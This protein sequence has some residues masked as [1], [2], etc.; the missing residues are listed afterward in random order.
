MKEPSIKEKRTIRFMVFIGIL[1]MT[2]FVFWFY[3]LGY[4]PSLLFWVLSISLG[5]GFLRI[6]YMWYHYISIKIPKKPHGNSKFTVDILTTYFPGEPYEMILET[7]DAIQK[8]TYPHT[9]YLCDEANDPYLKEACNKLNVVHVTRNNRINAKAGNINNALQQASGEICVVLD[10]DHIPQPHFLDPILPHFNDPK[11]GFVQIVQSYYNSKKSLVARGAAEQT[12]QFYGPMMM[13]MNRYGTVNAI[14]A[15]CTFRRAALDS[16]GGHAPGLS[17]D[18]HTAMLL[19]SKGWKSVYVPKVLAKGLVP[20]DLSTYYKQQLKWSRGTFDLLFYVYPKIAKFFSPLQKLHFALLP[21]HY[22]V[23]IIYLISFLIPI[24][25]LLLSESPWDGNLIHFMVIGLPLSLSVVLIR[26]YIQKWVIE[27]KERGFH[28]IG[29]LL[30]MNT[31]WIF[32]IG[33]IYTIF[34]KKIPYL[35]T[36]KTGSNR[37]PIK[38]ILPNLIIGFLSL[39]AIVYGLSKDFTPFSLFMAF[40]A[41]LN[42]LIMFF[43]IY[44]GANVTN[45][46]KILR[47][48]LKND[49]VSFL[50]K[51]KHSYERLSAQIFLVT[52]KLA[53]Y[54]LIIGTILFFWINRANQFGQMENYTYNYEPNF[55]SDQKYLGIF[56]PSNDK[57]VSN[58]AAIYDKEIKT[59]SQFAIIS[60]YHAWG[61]PSITPFPR[62][63]IDSIFAKGALPM[64]T[65]EPWLKT[66]PS[67]DTLFINT[68]A[69]SIF[70]KILEGIF[71]DYIDD[72]AQNLKSFESPI[73]LRFAHEFDNPA[74]PWSVNGNLSPDSYKAAWIYVFE[75]FKKKG[76][77]NVIWVWNPW[78][79]SVIADYYPGNEFVD[80]IGL[81]LL[82]YGS[83]N[84]NGKWISFSDIYLP[85]RE[86]LQKKRTE[87]H[88]ASRI[89][90]AGYWR[91]S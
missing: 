90:I 49:T 23:G 38:L 67:K 65:W 84:E 13:S 1:C 43:S 60:L 88:N 3:R 27:E 61:E 7:L 42:M 64:I 18:M 26:A 22:L 9:T 29:G 68:S 52:R 28:I 8:I 16:I 48:N 79:S 77:H 80:W 15:N 76:A 83:L 35:P 46:N 57:G 70:C 81:T 85:F 37:T 17:E 66:F 71:D 4:K 2:N 55:K 62:S 19:Y 89:W 72:Y 44:L 51:I 5:Y 30:Q 20:E 45:E 33:F 63:N 31:W 75:R 34:R 10:P 86:E 6:L 91:E 11:I 53:F 69:N 54:I 58:I 41:F 74:Y 40:F 47:T 32:L 12:F 39:F 50:V 56:H 73:F 21:L 24:L 82:N 36:P 87:T 14:G 25:S 59:N 78:K